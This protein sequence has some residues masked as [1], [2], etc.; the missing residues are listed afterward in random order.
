MF[1][2][3]EPILVTDWFRPGGF[4]LG[5]IPDLRAHQYWDPHHLTAQRLAADARDPQPEQDCCIRKSVLWDLAAVYPPGVKW[6]DRV[7]PATF[8]NGPVVKVQ[9]E[10]E[11]A[12]VA[13]H[14]S[15]SAGRRD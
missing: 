15:Q 10:F 1:A 6:T 9:E 13:S 3:W 8:F 4:V 12:L 2:V 7:P 14:L 5:R 11:N